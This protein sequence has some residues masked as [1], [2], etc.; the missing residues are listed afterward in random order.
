MLAPSNPNI[1]PINPLLYKEDKEENE[2]FGEDA[3]YL[4]EAEVDEKFLTSDRQYSTPS[5]F[6]EFAVYMPVSGGLHRFDFSERRYLKTIYNSPAKR[7]LLM[8]GRQVEKTLVLDSLISR[9][10]GSFVRAEDVIEG[11]RLT[12]M[13]QRDGSKIEVGEVSWKSRVYRKPCVKI[14]TRQGHECSVATTHPMRTWGSWTEAGNLKAGDRLAVVRKAGEFTAAV[15]ASQ[16]RIALTAYLIG[17]G[18]IGRYI[19]F[20]SVPGPQLNDFLR[21][22]CDAGGTVRVSPKSGTTAKDVRLHENG[23]VRDWLEEDGLVGSNSYTK[24]IPSW[25]FDLGREDTA[26][27][28]NR[29][30]STDGH[31][32]RNSSSKYSIEYCS[33]SH[34]L[35]RQVQALLWKFGVP[36]RIRE[37][38]PNYWKKRGIE[39]TAYILRVETVGG[40]STFLQ[41]IGALGKSENVPLPEVGSNNNRGTYPKEI[42][43]LIGDIL[44]SRGEDDWHENRDNNSLHEYGLRRSL[45]YPPTRE[46]LALY[47]DFFRMDRRFNQEMVDHL[48][49]H[50]DTD[51]Y[52]DT[53]VD[54]KDIGE[55]DCVDFEVSPHHNFVADGFVTHN[56]TLLGNTCLAYTALNPFFRALYVSPSNQQTKVFSRDRIK[57]PMEVSPVLRKYTSSKMLANVLEKKLVNFSQITLRFAFLNADRCR[58]IPADKVIIDEFQDILLENVPV[59]EECASHSTFK[60]FT[61]AGT[62]K[63]LDNAIEHYWSRFSTQNEWIVPCKRHGTPKD[64]G[65]WHWN[66]LDED[67]IGN[68]SLICDRCG[69]PIDPKDEDARWNSINPNPKVEKP[70]EGYR[71]PQ[72]MVPWIEHA[73]ILDKQR[74]YSRAKF[75]NEVLGRSYDSGTRPLTRA[76]LLKNSWNQLSMAYYRDVIKWTSQYPVFMGVDWGCHDEQTRILTQRGFVHFKDLTDDDQVAQFDERTR[77]MS[78]V[79]P[80]VRTV[81]DWDG[82]L[83]HFKAK[84]LDMMLTDTHRMLFKGKNGSEFKVERAGD[85]VERTGQ[86]KFVG[87]TFFDGQEQE[88]FE[89]PGLPSSAGYSGAEAQTFAMDDWLE[90]L[91]YFLSEGGLCWVPSRSGNGE[92]RPSC[93]K[94]SQRETVNPG[95]TAKIRDCMDR[96]GIEYSESTNPKTGDVNWTI[97]DKQFWHWVEQNVGGSSATKRIPREFLR[98]S[99]RQLKILWDAMML[100]DGTV[101]G[102]ENCDNG[103]YSS[104]SKQLCEDFQELSTLLGLRSTLKLHKEAEGNRKDRWSVSWSSGRD[105]VVFNDPSRAERVL[106]KG[107]VYC[108]RVPT[109]FIVTERNGCIGYQG[110]TGEGTYTVMVLGGYLPFAPDKFTYF[111]MRRF[112]GVE[113]E[114]DR[115]LEII[116]DHIRDFNVRFVGVDYGGGFWPNDKLMREFGANKIKKYQWVGNQKKKIV[117]EPR[118]AVP[119]YLCHRSEV[120]SDMFNAIKRSNVFRYPRWEEFDDPHAMDFLN[121]YSEYNE[122]TRMNV[123]KHAP[124]NPDDTFHAC[125]YAFLASYFV[126]QR[127]DVLVPSQDTATFSEE[128]NDERDYLTDRDDQM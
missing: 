48:E 98:L 27:F 30:W 44:G 76:D 80:M 42:N 110:N 99:Q 61:Y 34:T 83:L 120:M 107:K 71:I 22:V 7:R 36:T 101:D 45:K 52:W 87:T 102:R 105:Y 11:D 125:T 116:K 15:S 95:T 23:S 64:S 86:V 63:S 118:L 24:F 88:S 123:Y 84:G 4:D 20:T 14:K 94:M 29:L 40:V 8:A 67:N 117:Y 113:S 68:K 35:V 38:W 12:S 37:N 114:P 49:A 90:F 91:G 33:M 73:D 85:F 21:C 115:Q 39:K 75:Y 59:I 18:Y 124:G 74:K 77:E 19:S 65:S 3:R 104:T 60:L 54:I 66:I 111:Y 2:H 55:Q 16:E 100:G 92:K 121:I 56:S 43:N 50:L 108:C 69:K 26:L 13:E 46:K 106:Y 17:D 103:S 122:R 79:K 72:L 5:Q 126:K 31:V 28:L 51:L 47:V 1:K 89:L 112:D 57:E 78:F 70:F 41:D 119:R 9:E 62:P 10:N 97:W 128:W 53:I 82:E 81:R 93:L 6:I 58:G 109:G 127:P 32:K 25:V 96:L